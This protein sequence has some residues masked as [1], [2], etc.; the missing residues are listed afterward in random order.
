MLA[1][2]HAPQL[3]ADPEAWLWS[4]E[5]MEREA[6]QYF[7]EAFG[8]GAPRWIP[9]YLLPGLGLLYQVP[10]APRCFVTAARSVAAHADRVRGGMWGGGIESLSYS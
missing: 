8:I 6:R 4:S 9:G 10:G 7:S 3:A 1:C 5:A 2:G